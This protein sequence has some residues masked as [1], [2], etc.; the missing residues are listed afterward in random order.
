MLTIS[1]ALMTNSDV[2][3]LNTATESLAPHGG[4]MARLLKPS[5]RQARAA[6]PDTAPDALRR[7]CAK[8]GSPCSRRRP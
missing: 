5:N 4:T 2:L 3:I 6:T 8:G 1:R 7:C